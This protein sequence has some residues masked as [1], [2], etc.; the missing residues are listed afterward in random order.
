MPRK[1]EPPLTTQQAAAVLGVTPRGVH[2]MVE[3]GVL[4]ATMF[5]KSLAI[6]AASVEAAKTRTGR[7]R[8]K[9]NSE[10]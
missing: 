7:G 5:G 2:K 9:K 4:R 10:H 8:P 1:A 3:S 6:D